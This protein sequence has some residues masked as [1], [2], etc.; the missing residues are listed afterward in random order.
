V[1]LIKKIQINVPQIAKYVFVGGTCASVEFIVFSLLVLNLHIYYMV[2][3]I[4]AAVIVT[5]IGFWVQK[6]WTFKNYNN[7]H[8]R[9]MIKYFTITGIGFLLDNLLVFLFIGVLKLH[10]FIGKPLQL[11]LVFFWNY[12]GQRFWTFRIN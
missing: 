4:C 5:F 8:I 6:Y 11:F 2:A 9:Q 10:I 1:I 3:N 7:K 12:S